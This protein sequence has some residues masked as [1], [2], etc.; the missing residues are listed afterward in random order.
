MDEITKQQLLSLIEKHASGTCTEAEEEMLTKWFDEN[1][2]I[3]WLTFVSDEEKDNIKQTIYSSVKKRINANYSVNNKV[4]QKKLWTVRVSLAAMLCIGFILI[5][6]AYKTVTNQTITVSAPDG[7]DK[8]PV[9][10]PD[11][12]LVLLS[13][14]SS[15]SYPIAFGNNSRE[16]LLVG[17]AYFSVK[18][19][20]NLP[21]ELKTTKAITVK[22]LGTSFVVDVQKETEYIK[23]SVITGKVQIDRGKNTLDV[24]LPGERMSYSTGNNTF[25][26]NKYIPG[27]LVKWKNDGLIYLKAV[28]LNELSVVLSTVYKV[29]L[30]FDD[31]LSSQYRFNMSFSKHLGVE[32]VLNMLETTSDLKFELNGRNVNTTKK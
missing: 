6:F 15:V 31:S 14:N 1:P 8:L 12:S 26:K 4:K 30:I 24:L 20:K 27:E 18:P 16:V 5:Y 25:L 3:A 22:V 2:Q 29:D 17:E 23:I 13:A 21:F 11:S 32:K 19:N 7:V 9:L 10:L 28:S